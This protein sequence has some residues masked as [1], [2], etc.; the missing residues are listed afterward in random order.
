MRFQRI[1]PAFEHLSVLQ[2]HVARRRVH[3]TDGD[4]KP[5]DTHRI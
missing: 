3:R 2:R 5:N 4:D 1:I